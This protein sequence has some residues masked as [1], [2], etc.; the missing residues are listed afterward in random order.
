MWGSSALKEGKAGGSRG[1]IVTRLLQG[2]KKEERSSKC[3]EGGG[4]GRGDRGREG[5]PAGVPWQA[6]FP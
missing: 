4:A 3:S 2:E 6:G 1:E 5:K